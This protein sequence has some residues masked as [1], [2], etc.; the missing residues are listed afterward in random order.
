ML[1]VRVDKNGDHRLCL[2]VIADPSCLRSR[3]SLSCVCGG[4]FD[5]APPSCHGKQGTN[6]ARPL[7]IVFDT[8]ENSGAGLDSGVDVERHFVKK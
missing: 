8:G 7:R 6:L 4:S 2:L 1:E 3:I 5:N